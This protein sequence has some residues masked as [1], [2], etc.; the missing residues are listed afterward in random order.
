MKQS[1]PMQAASH[2]NLYNMKLLYESN[3]KAKKG[4]RHSHYKS[5]CLFSDSSLDIESFR[6]D[7]I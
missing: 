3:E 7:F 2:F 5:R 6:S 4:P 1:P